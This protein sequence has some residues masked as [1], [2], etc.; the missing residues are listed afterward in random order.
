MKTRRG[1]RWARLVLAAVVAASGS[2]A[3]AAPGMAATTVTPSAPA[4]WSVHT[5]AT[6][7]PPYTAASSNPN[8]SA[9]FAF[10]PGP[11]GAPAGVG[12]LE[13]SPGQD[14]NSRVAAAPPVLQNVPLSSLTQLTY[15]SYQAAPGGPD[16]AP[17]PPNFK[18]ATQTTNF[19]FRTL[20]FEPDRPTAT[21]R[22]LLGSW[23]NWNAVTGIWWTNAVPNT[24]PCGQ[25][26]PC[27]LPQLQQLVGADSTV[28]G[29]YFEMGDSGTGFT[30]AVSFL[31]NVTI[32]GSSWDFEPLPEPVEP[33]TPSI[34]EKSGAVAPGDFQV[35]TASG[36]LPHEQVLLTV[37]TP[38]FTV[39][40][41]TANAS[42]TVTF[43]F[44]IPAGFPVGAHTA[45]LVGLTS[46]RELAIVFLVE[47][48]LPI[49][50]A[51]AA[52]LAG[53][54][55]GALVAGAVLLTTA[56]ALRRR[57]TRP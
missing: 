26:N 6:A 48:G 17:L 55:L 27:P 20:V 45:R 19:G 38:S 39:G 3:W 23:Q 9:T 24:Q 50:G 21:P 11:P 16:N 5:N 4:G 56:A 18:L 25:S 14:A 46:G 22:P 57:T 2:L 30:G 52:R 12:S 8:T 34:D 53:W 1:A 13:L 43:R 33:G 36:F 44:Q 32:N 40:P 51:P 28:L 15:S 49:T 42:G 47:A 54:G 31:D 37:N 29:A 41:E 7:T 10:V 35:I